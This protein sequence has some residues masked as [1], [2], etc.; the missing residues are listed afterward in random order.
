VLLTQSSAEE[1]SA[2]FPD[3]PEQVAEAEA[4]LAL[5]SSQ[6]KK[7][8]KKKKK[9]K[10][11]GTGAS[12]EA[13][14]GTIFNTEVNSSTCEGENVSSVEMILA[15]GSNNANPDD[16]DDDEVFLDLEED[17]D[18]EVARFSE[19]LESVHI[20]PSMKIKFKSQIPLSK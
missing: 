2:T 14:P 3:N 4:A 10:K 20:G 8:R 18:D 13:G 7:K 6:A 9:K 15:G 19:M 11:M 16:D 12:I 1:L 17:V 5:K